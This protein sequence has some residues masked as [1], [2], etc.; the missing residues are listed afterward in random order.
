MPG[1]S[2]PDK[3]ILS[4]LA[5]TVRF[6][7]ESLANYEFS[8]YAQGLY[9]FIWRDLCD[10]Y[11][12]AIKP[13][14]SENPVQRRVL[15]LCL[16]A[17][18][19]LLH[20]VMP[21]ITEK[22]WGKLNEV[23]PVREISGVTLTPSDLLITAAWP[24][25]APELIDAGAEAEFALVQEVISTI[26]QVRTT[27]KVPPKQKVLISAKAPAAIAS[28]LLPQKD[29]IETLANVTCGE[30]GPKVEKPA[31]AAAAMVAGTE[32]YLHGLVQ[33][34]AEKA[35]LTKRLE[36]VTKSVAALQGR[37]ANKSYADRAPANLVQQ[38]RDQLAAAEKE[39]EALRVQVAAL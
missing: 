36:E 13:T 4:R 38:T 21:F 20:P 26:R 34:D 24:L 32:H 8:A 15:A 19:R 17:S 12:E 35:R 9:D 31:D 27:Y 29:L 7:N 2:L 1:L 10:W 18:L 5:A 23:A 28:R 25:V 6:T 33:A 39:A 37:L 3:W 11:I 14:A 22:L 16:D 30:I